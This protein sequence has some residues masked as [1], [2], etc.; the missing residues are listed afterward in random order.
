M[1]SLSELR[2]RGVFVG[3]STTWKYH[4]ILFMENV[5]LMLLENSSLIQVGELISTSKQTHKHTIDS[6][7][8]LAQYWDGKH[9]TLCINYYHIKKTNDVNVLVLRQPVVTV[10]H[11]Y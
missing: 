9:A 11:K 3:E 5:T 10:L 7:I 2:V 8:D 6:I 4:S 1:Y